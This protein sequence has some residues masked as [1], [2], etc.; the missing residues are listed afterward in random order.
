M[1]Y[2]ATARSGFTNYSFA[3]VLRS[4][5]HLRPLICVYLFLPWILDGRYRYPRNCLRATC[6]RTALRLLFRFHF[7]Y[8][9]RL[10]GPLY[11]FVTMYYYYGYYVHLPCGRRSFHS[12]PIFSTLV[13]KMFEGLTLYSHMYNYEWPRGCNMG[14]R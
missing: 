10:R 3:P 5:G 2:R 8:S 11:P 13:V 12:V 6:K 4:S 9:P 14:C 1:L 7:L